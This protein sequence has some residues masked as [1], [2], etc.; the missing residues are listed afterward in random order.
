M[1]SNEHDYTAILGMYKTQAWLNF[2]NILKKNARNLNEPE[3]LKYFKEIGNAKNI[4]SILKTHQKF[5]KK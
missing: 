3:T 4:D 5:F 1:L 2:L